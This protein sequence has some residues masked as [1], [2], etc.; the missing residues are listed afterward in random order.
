MFDIGEGGAYYGNNKEILC[1]KHFKEQTE[2]L[3]E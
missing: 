3:I 1:W 2:M